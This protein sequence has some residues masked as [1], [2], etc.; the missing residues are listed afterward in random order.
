MLLLAALLASLHLM[1]SPRR[2]KAKTHTGHSSAL[3]NHQRAKRG[4]GHPP[5]RPTGRRRAKAARN[6]RAYQQ[7]PTPE[8]YAQIQQALAD[9]GYYHGQTNGQ[10]GPDSVQALRKYQQDHQLDG[11]GK[12]TSLS[13]IGLG[14]GPKRALTAQAAPQPA[15]PP[16]PNSNVLQPAPA[17]LPPIQPQQNGP[18]EQ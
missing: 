7:A 8:R 11:D 6:R 10:W 18:T 14:L 17:N 15:A 4:I 3:P 13:L 2:K 12:I 9:R 5:S 1:A 16:I